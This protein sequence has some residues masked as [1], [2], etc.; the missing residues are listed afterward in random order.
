M[1]NSPG[2]A[3]TVSDMYTKLYSTILDSSIWSSSDST[4]LVWITMLAMA[5]KNGIV[6]AS[7]DGLARRAN[8]P[9]E[10]VQDALLELSSPDPQDKSGVRDGR[11]IVAMQGCWQLVNFDFYRETRSIDAVRKQQWRARQ[12]GPNVQDKS[13]ATAS[14]QDNAPRSAPA[15]APDQPRSAPEEEI[16][17][18][19]APPSVD[20]LAAL[21][22][23]F[24]E[25][26]TVHGHPT[27]KLDEKRKALIRRALKLHTAEQL[28]QAIRGAL[29]DDWIM[30][31]DP[32]STKKYD[33]IETLLRDTAQIER[34]I[35]L[36]TGKTKPNAN[37]GRRSKIHQPDHGKTGWE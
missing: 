20:C 37:P 7:V 19:P 3:M 30:G 36:E 26:Q 8:V 9:L 32:K 34:L 13:L 2:H 23:V 22:G 14:V 15:P 25:W 5:T 29:K 21:K 12:P 24:V 31:R 17:S 16:S 35:D 27:S 28:G 6:H 18:S 11:R 10:R 4:R 33:G 1:I